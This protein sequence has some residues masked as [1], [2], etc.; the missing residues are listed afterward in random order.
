MYKRQVQK[1][2]G[3]NGMHLPVTSANAAMIDELAPQE[4]EIV[5]NKTTDS[6]VNGTNYVRLMQNMRCV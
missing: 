5:V 6:V 3:W 2:D 4:N 1:S